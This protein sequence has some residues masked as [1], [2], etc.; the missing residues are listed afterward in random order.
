MAIVGA[1]IAFVGPLFISTDALSVALIAQADPP[2]GFRLRVSGPVKVALIPSIDLVAEDVGVAK[3]GN[4]EARE[5]AT[6]KKLRFGLRL[7]ALFGD[8]V[9]MTE[10]ALIDPVIAL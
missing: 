2:T 10:I 4:G 6:A 7:S 9:K 3:G 8:K 1:I 5:M